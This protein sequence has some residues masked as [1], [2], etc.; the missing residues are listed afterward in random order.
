[1]D[2]LPIALGI[3]VVLYVLAIVWHSNDLQRHKQ[4]YTTQRRV[5]TL[6]SLH[7]MRKSLFISGCILVFHSV[8]FLLPALLS[9]GAS[10]EWASVFGLTNLVYASVLWGVWVWNKRLIGIAENLKIASTERGKA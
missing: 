5:R 2:F 1:M 7:L 4:T 6:K 9:T 3:M 10:R 8:F